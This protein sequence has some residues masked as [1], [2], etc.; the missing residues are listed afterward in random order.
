[1]EAARTLKRKEGAEALPMKATEPILTRVE[2]MAILEEQANRI[3]LCEL[4]TT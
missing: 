1:L 4:A 3:T 2:K